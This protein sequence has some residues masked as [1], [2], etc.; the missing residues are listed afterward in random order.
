MS[1]KVT[2]KTKVQSKF[3]ELPVWSYFQVDSNIYI[4]VSCS[5]DLSH[6]GQNFN[7]VDVQ[8][9][10]KMFACNQPI[11]HVLDVEVLLK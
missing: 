8:G 3:Q 4:K 10:F 6:K 9:G 1:V 7:A 5:K 11:K 2:D